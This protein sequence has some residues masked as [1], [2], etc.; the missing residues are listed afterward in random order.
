MRQSAT[1]YEHPKSERQCRAP[2]LRA[3]EK[4]EQQQQML[5]ALTKMHDAEIPVCSAKVSFLASGLELRGNE[6]LN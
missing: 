5:E 2:D 4:V 1:R 3:E 6:R